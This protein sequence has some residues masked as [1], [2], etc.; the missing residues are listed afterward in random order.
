M[1]IDRIN[2]LKSHKDYGYTYDMELISNV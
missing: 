2:K 1:R